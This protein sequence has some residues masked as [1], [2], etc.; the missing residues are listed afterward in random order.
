MKIIHI[1]PN[2]KRGGAERICIDICNE[3]QRQGHDVLLILFSPENEYSEITNQLNIKVIPSS[4]TPSILKSNLVEIKELEKAVADFKP[5]VIHSHLY[6]ADLVAYQLKA[7]NIKFFSHIHS[8][9]KELVNNPQVQNIKQKVIFSFEKR[10]YLNL[11]KKKNVHLIAISKDCH[12]FVLNDLARKQESVTFLANCI[13]FNLFKSNPKKINTDLPVRLIAVGRFTANKAQE[14]LV[15]VA[16]HLKGQKIN[17]ELSFLGDGA[18][19]N[20]V[21]ELAKANSLN[22]ITFLNLVNNPEEELKKAHIFVHSARKE[23]FGLSLIE[24]MAAGLPVITTDGGGNRDIMTDND[25]GFM[26]K[27]RDAELF[28][29]QV[30][31]LINSPSDYERISENCVKYAAQ[32]DVNNYVKT[33]LGLYQ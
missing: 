2:L 13:N 7:K 27:S 24:A 29:N 8:N 30:I 9:R 25:N 26:I 32:Y 18:E 17:F 5:D 10:M 4:F 19:L 1:I 21:K 22:E 28:A 14:F 31:Q 6:E 20:K 11:L 23:A 12:E 16:K 3:L 15:Q 33:L